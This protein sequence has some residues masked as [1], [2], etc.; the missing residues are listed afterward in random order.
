MC[1]N[2]RRKTKENNKM[3]WDDKILAGMK[4]IMEGCSENPL[5]AECRGC[6]FDTLCTSIYKDDEH[7]FS[8]PD[9]WEEEGIFDKE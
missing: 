2:G 3:T 6:P 5:W 9:T 8:T 7:H 4:M 1:Y